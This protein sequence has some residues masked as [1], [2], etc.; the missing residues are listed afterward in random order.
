LIKVVDHKK[1]GFIQ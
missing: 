1:Q